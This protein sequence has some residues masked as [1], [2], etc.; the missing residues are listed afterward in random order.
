MFRAAQRVGAFFGPAFCWVPAEC[1]HSGA[2][3]TP[4]TGCVIWERDLDMS[5]VPDEP[6]LWL[7]PSTQ[8]HQQLLATKSHEAISLAKEIIGSSNDAS[9]QFP[10]PLPAEGQLLSLAITLLLNPSWQCR[11][12]DA[13]VFTQMSVRSF[14]RHF[15]R[16]TGVGFTYWRRLVICEHADRLLRDGRSMSYIVETLGYRSGSAFVAMYR[17]TKGIAP[18]RKISRE[19]ALLRDRY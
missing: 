12:D 4:Y 2:A 15:R 19:L 16:A 9:T 1:V 8:E 3:L 6:T 7:L 14:S 13:A 18:K 10:I 11:A 17:R 5:D